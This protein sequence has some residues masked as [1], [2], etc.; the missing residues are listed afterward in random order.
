ME[1]LHGHSPVG[2]RPRQ[3]QRWDAMVGEGAHGKPAEEGRGG[4]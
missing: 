1:E 3:G 4:E 2:A